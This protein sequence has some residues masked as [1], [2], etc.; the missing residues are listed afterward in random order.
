MAAA[1]QARRSLV[2]ASLVA[3]ALATGW[4]VPRTTARAAE[5]PAKTVSL[6]VDYGD[7]SQKQFTA[8]AWREGLTVLDAVRAA[9][10]H[11]RG[12]KCELRGSGDTAFLVK[13]DDLKN[14]GGAGRGWMFR[15]NGKLADRSLGVFPLQA[16]DAVLWKFEKYR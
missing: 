4:T 3:T 11:P 14:E 13:I 2:L 9:E 7:G 12:I 1:F 16:G 6:A 15:V 8:L 10:K 5:E